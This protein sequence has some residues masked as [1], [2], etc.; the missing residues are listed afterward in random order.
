MRGSASE[1]KIL[2]RKDN[3]MPTKRD[4]VLKQWVGVDVVGLDAMIAGWQNFF[5]KLKGRNATIRR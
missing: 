3:G 1:W 5:P 4:E 2:S